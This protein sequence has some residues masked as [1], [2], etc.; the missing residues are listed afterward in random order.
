MVC[1]CVIIA[2]KVMLIFYKRAFGT[3]L[4]LSLSQKTLF[5]LRFKEVKF[6]HM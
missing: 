4:L 5:F 2:N 3:L 6:I 1:V